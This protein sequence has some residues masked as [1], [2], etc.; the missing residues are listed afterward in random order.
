MFVRSFPHCGL[1]INTWA[2]CDLVKVIVTGV[3]EQGSPG[4]SPI[5][6]AWLLSSMRSVVG[7]R[8]RVVSSVPTV[9]SGHSILSWRLTKKQDVHF[10]II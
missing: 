4:G 7:V 5:S 3:A 10:S 1:P 9:E 8:T 2:T 6:N